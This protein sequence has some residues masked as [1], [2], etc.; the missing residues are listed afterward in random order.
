MLIFSTASSCTTF[1][2]PYKDWRS[3]ICPL[4]GITR[5]SRVS[6]RTYRRS[7]ATAAL[8]CALCRWLAG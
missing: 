8:S 5:E 2:F 4:S 7:H 1:R 6:P 3:P